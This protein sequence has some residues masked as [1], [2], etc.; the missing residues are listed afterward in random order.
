MALVNPDCLLIPD[1]ELE[2]T[3]PMGKLASPVEV[4][5]LARKWDAVEC[6]V[7]LRTSCID[8]RDIADCF[9]VLKSGA[10]FP[11]AGIDRRILDRRRRN[12]RERRIISGSRHMPHGVLLGEIF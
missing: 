6:L 9:P 1:D 4:F 3:R 11:Q 7:L 2:P 8:P 5:K 10:P 12:A